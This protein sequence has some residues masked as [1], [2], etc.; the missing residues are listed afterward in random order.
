MSGKK[1]RR[2][3]VQ[4]GPREDHSDRGLRSALRSGA[5]ADGGKQAPEVAPGEQGGLE[6]EGQ[7]VRL[8]MKSGCTEGRV[9]RLEFKFQL[10]SRDHVGWSRSCSKPW[11]LL[12]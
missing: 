1:N 7:D 6:K 8:R 2:G 5:P 10:Y 9:R 4:G 3:G 12:R 11:F